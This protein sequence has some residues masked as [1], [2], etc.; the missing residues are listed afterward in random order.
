MR[1]RQP[2]NSSRNSSRDPLGDYP[3]R[4]LQYLE[5]QQYARATSREYQR[6]LRALVDYM[7]E[8]RIKMASLDE[9]D[10]RRLGRGCGAR[11]K[12]YAT[13]II[14]RFIRYLI[15]AGAVRPPE[16][17]RDDSPLARLRQEYEE[18]LRVQRGLSERSI[19]HCWRFA[20]RP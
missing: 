20:D 3:E 8:E 5:S 11:R 7:R 16:P 10:A 9:A 19:Y 13:F 12:Q 4:F 1:K 14:R 15:D 17:H 18:Y 6:C 2:K